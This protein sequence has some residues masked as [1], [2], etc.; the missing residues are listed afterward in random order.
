MEIFSLYSEIF[1]KEKDI[2]NILMLTTIYLFD[3][4][5][6][7]DFQDYY[8]DQTVDKNRSFI[9]AN[10]YLNNRKNEKFIPFLFY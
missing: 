9:T 4:F 1:F 10:T 5:Q 8:L 7:R 3:V 6:L 2:P